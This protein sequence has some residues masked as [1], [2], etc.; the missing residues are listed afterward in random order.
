MSPTLLLDLRLEEGYTFAPFGGRIYREIDYY[1]QCTSLY[2]FAP[3][4][5]IILNSSQLDWA[6]LIQT[7]HCGFHDTKDECSKERLDFDDIHDVLNA[8]DT[9]WD[10][11]CAKLLF[12]NILVCLFVGV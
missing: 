5:L 11:E 7:I 1:L 9:E 2:P 12:C 6:S 4:R 8:M 3:H 10:Q